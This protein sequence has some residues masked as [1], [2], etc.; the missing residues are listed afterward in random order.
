MKNVMAP[1]WFS[2][3]LGQ[4]WV[5]RQNEAYL[6]LRPVGRGHCRATE[7]RRAVSSLCLCGAQVKRRVH[8]RGVAWGPRMSDGVRFLRQVP[9]EKC[10]DAKGHRDNVRVR[11]VARAMYRS[12]SLVNTGRSWPMSSPL[13]SPSWAHGH[14]R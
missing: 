9:L 7:A 13:Q 3:F 11:H 12:V 1:M 5:A 14:Q 6:L 10:S 8:R 4:A 2:T